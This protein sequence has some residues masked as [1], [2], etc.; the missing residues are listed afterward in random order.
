MIVGRRSAG[1]ENV[2]REV[3]REMEREEDGRERGGEVRRVVREE[4]QEGQWR[5]PMP[6]LGLAGLNWSWGRR[7]EEKSRLP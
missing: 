1:W 4:T 3:S 6:R 7:T 5:L 2:T